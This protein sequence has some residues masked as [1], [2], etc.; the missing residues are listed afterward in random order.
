MTLTADRL[1]DLLH[2]D[3]DTGL[4]I[5]RQS[6]ARRIKVGSPA[7]TVSRKGYVKIQIDRKVYSAH[8]LAWLYIHGRWPEHSIDHINRV[9]S[10][11]RAVNLRDATDSQNA[12][13]CGIRKTNTSGY[14]GVSY[15]RKSKKWAAQIYLQGKNTLLGLFDTPEMAAEAYASA[16]KKHNLE[17]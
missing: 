2:Y 12:R 4:F 1:R 6:A 11:N 16:A 5:W 14:K 9:R 17:W 3:P 13:N 10:D 15:W 7:G 8:R